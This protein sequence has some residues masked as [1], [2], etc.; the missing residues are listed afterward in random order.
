[1]SL[2]DLTAVTAILKSR[3]RSSLLSVLL[4]L[5][6]L[7]LARIFVSLPTWQHRLVKLFLI[8][9]VGIVSAIVRVSVVSVVKRERSWPEAPPT[10]C[11]LPIGL[12]L[13][14]VVILCCR[15]WWKE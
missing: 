6:L 8:V 4:S 1:M 3:C 9:K 5:P 7:L 11:F 15:M 12:A 13:V 2:S 10:A 14:I